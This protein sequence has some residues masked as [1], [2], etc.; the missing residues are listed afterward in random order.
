MERFCCSIGGWLDI[1]YQEAGIH[2]GRFHHTRRQLLSLLIGNKEL[3]CYVLTEASLKSL[4]KNFFFSNFSGAPGISRQKSQDIP[5]K[6]WFSWVLKDIPNSLDPA[7]RG[8]E[9][10]YADLWAPGTFLALST[11]KPAHKIFLV[12]G[13]LVVFGSGGR[14]CQSYSHGRGDFSECKSDIFCPLRNLLKYLLRTFVLPQI[15]QKLLPFAFLP[16]ALSGWKQST[17]TP[18][19]LRSGNLIL[20]GVGI[21]LIFHS[22][23]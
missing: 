16:L 5:T 13:G 7:I 17:K 23:W 20:M 11:G 22:W 8:P 21:L 3:T 18:Q 4:C 19:K 15:F 10:G 12:L 14:K 9:V 6:V 1:Y 2:N